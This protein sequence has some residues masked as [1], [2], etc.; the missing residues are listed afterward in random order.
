MIIEE[1]YI[2]NNLRMKNVI[3]SNKRRV[4]SNQLVRKRKRIHKIPHKIIIIRFLQNEMA[5][6]EQCTEK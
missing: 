5:H 1:I 6:K 4:I 2:E 3:I